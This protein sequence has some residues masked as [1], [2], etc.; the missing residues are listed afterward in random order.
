[1]VVIERSL[2]RTHGLQV[3][4]L[5]GAAD[6]HYLADRL[7]LRAERRGGPVEFLERESG[8]LHDHIIQGRLEAGERLARDVIRDFVE[9]EADGEKG[10]DLRDREPCRL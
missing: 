9:R 5:E 4:L 8:D 10:G 6:G 3:R 7:H 1:M 2:Q